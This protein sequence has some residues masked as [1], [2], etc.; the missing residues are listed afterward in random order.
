[1]ALS[2]EQ[3]TEPVA[4][5]RALARDAGRPAPQVV[6]MT[7]LPLDDPARAAD[8]ACAFRE[9][10]VTGLVH[11]SRYADAASFQRTA[12]ALALHVRPALAGR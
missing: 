1:M 4:A 8:A 11:G 7:G 2:P 5:L 10:G 6:L 3:L 12:E 9:A